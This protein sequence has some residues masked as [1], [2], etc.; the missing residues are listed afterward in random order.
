[1]FDGLKDMGNLLKKA[2]EMKSQMKTVQDELKKIEIKGSAAD[3]KVQVVIT[4]EMEIVSVHIAEDI[5]NPKNQ[6]LIQKAVK[7]AVSD[8]ITE[9]KTVAAKK[10][11]EVTGGLNLPGLG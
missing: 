7:K 10:L 11:T 8:A 4:G 6:V 9:S 3:G 1:M 2:R 5:L